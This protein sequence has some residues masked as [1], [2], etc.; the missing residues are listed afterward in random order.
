MVLTQSVVYL[1]PLLWSVYCMADITGKS[2]KEPSISKKKHNSLSRAPDIDFI[3]MAPPLASKNANVLKDKDISTKAHEEKVTHAKNN[4]HPAIFL[5][6]MQIKTFWN[7][8][9]RKNK[10]RR[11]LE[12]ILKP[13]FFVCCLCVLV[14]IY[15]LYRA[16]RIRRSI[17]NDKHVIQP[18]DSKTIYQNEA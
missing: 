16:V 3:M 2:P 18:T 11:L 1:V 10:S 6:F 8:N 13:M 14:L 9:D 12:M 4:T 15:L 5:R 17:K 7:S